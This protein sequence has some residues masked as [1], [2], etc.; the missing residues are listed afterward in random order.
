MLA[1]KLGRLGI[2][3]V[4]VPV[5]VT[6]CFAGLLVMIVVD[7]I[8]LLPPRPPT[9]AEVAAATPQARVSWQLVYHRLRKRL[10]PEQTAPPELG[11]VWATRNG[12]ICGL[13][14]KVETGVPFMEPFYTVQGSPVFKSEDQFGYM[15]NWLVCAFDQW[16]ML[17]PGTYKTGF[18]ATKAGRRSVLG[19]RRCWRR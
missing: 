9:P 4:F 2:P 16:V 3:D 1:Q 18:C 13:V 5:S 17:N 10:P 19:Q 14:G 6:A 15:K 8:A 12:Q 7:Q 11:A